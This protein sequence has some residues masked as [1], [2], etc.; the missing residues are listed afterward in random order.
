MATPVIK[1]IT[2]DLDGTLVGGGNE[3]A[4]FKDFA[5]R[6]LVYR[7]RFGAQWAICTGR[8]MHSFE[9]V[10]APMRAMGIEPDYV[11]IHHAFIYRRGWRGYWPHLIWNA[12]I[13]FQ[14][15]SSALYLRGA[16][17]EWLRM[18]RGMTKGVTTIYHR[19]N[20]LCL[21]FRTEEDAESAAELLRRKASVFKHLRVF[22]YMQEV[23]VRAVPFTKGM[24][25]S[26]L[27]DRIRVKHS[28]ILAIGN[29]HNDISMLDG[30]SAAYTGCP[31]NAEVD[32]METVH[33]S[34]GHVATQRGLE[35]VIEILDAYLAGTV[36]SVLPEWWVPNRQQKNPN[37]GGR[38][39]NH[40]GRRSGGR[41]SS[42]VALQ[43]GV[44]AVY[45]VLVVLASFGVIPFS[46][47][48]MKPFTLVS[49][50]VERLLQGWG[51]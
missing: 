38:N 51:L 25:M 9:A 50:V 15:W 22:H 12:G 39:M 31:A 46:G 45:T 10:L 29:G 36:N 27:A 49:K 26:E 35:G 20:R 6:L 19:S 18:V 11:I 30:S 33:N 16:L 47:V 43:L 41:Q 21:R 48:I 32:V 2:T 24:A 28:E 42:R 1:L 13:R 14:V 7:Q 23:D 17:N 44:L 37:S 3:F 4:L 5:D 40:P 8:S 34:G